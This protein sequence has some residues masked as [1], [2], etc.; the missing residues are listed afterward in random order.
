M[1]HQENSSVQEIDPFQ[2]PPRWRQRDG[3]Q[4]AFQLCLPLRD[5]P[6]GSQRLRLRHQVQRPRGNGRRLDGRLHVLVG[7]HHVHLR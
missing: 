4:P 7:S 1:K 6:D 3:D 5:L 2:F